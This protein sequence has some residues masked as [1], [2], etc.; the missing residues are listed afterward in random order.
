MLTLHEHQPEYTDAEINRLRAENDRL[1]KKIDQLTRVKSKFQ[2]IIANISDGVL[3]IDRTGT[4]VETTVVFEAITNLKNEEV[5][6][7]AIWDIYRKINLTDS[8]IH[9]SMS[10]KCMPSI[11][12]AAQY[13]AKSL[14]KITH[15]EDG[16]VIYLKAEYFILRDNNEDYI[17]ITI[18]DTTE[19]E[20]RQRQHNRN[21]KRLRLAIKERTE[22]LETLNEEY[23][24]ANE[25]LLVVNEELAQQIAAKNKAQKELEE[26][27]IMFSSFFEQSREGIL[28][29]DNTGKIIDVNKVVEYIALLS[30]DQ[31]LGQYIWDIAQQTLA[32]PKKRSGY[33]A[34]YKE[35]VLDLLKSKNPDEFREEYNL[36]V[37]ESDHPRYIHALIFQII[38]HQ[39]KF[40]GVILRDNT[41]KYIYEEELKLYRD[42][43]ERLVYSKSAALVENEKKL[44]T[45]SDNFPN[46]FIY[47]MEKDIQTSAMNITYLS[48]RFTEMTGIEREHVLADA[49]A[50]FQ[51]MEP[52]Y[53]KYITDIKE[54]DHLEFT[55]PYH[56]A[57][58]E[59]RWVR[60]SAT[61][62]MAE[63]D[64]LINDGFV[65]DITEQVKASEALV[66]SEH[67][68]QS[69]FNR[70]Q[71]M[72][73]II[74]ANAIITYV[75]PS[76]YTTYG[77]TE[78]QMLGKS[79][80]SFIYPD[81]VTTVTEYMQYI[82]AHD[83]IPDCRYRAIKA[84]GEIAE[85][86]AVGVNMLHDP[87]I[88]GIVVTH[89]EVTK[90]VEAQKHI[91]YS[92]D[93]QRLLNS[94]LIP[95]QKS[96]YIGPILQATICKV[97]KFL[98]A[99]EASIWEWTSDHVNIKCINEWSANN[100]DLSSGVQMT[101]RKD[102]FLH[103]VAN[104]TESEAVTL[105][106]F[107]HLTPEL[108]NMLEQRQIDSLILMP[109][110]V[111]GNIHGMILMGDI[112]Q[113]QWSN[114]EKNL[115]ISVAQIVSSAL[116]KQKAAQAQIEAQQRIARNLERQELLNSVLV[117]LQKSNNL[118]ESI[119]SA[120]TEVGRYARVSRVSV[121]ELSDNE[122]YVNY[123]YEWCEVGIEP[124]IDKFNRY[125]SDTFTPLWKAFSDKPTVKVSDIKQLSPVLQHI[126]KQQQTQSLLF[127]PLYVDGALK[128][129][130]CFA[131]CH[132]QREWTDDEV[133]LLTGFAQILSSSLQQLKAEVAQE[134]VRQAM[135]TVLDNTPLQIYV[136]D[137]TTSEIL[138]ANLAVKNALGLTENQSLDQESFEKTYGPIPAI[139]KQDKI[140]EVVTFEYHNQRTNSWTQKTGSI[141][142]WIDGRLVHIIT[143]IDITERKKMELELL[144]A[145]EK[146]EESDRLKSAFLANMSHEIRTPMNGIVGFAQ[147]IGREEI[148]E[149]GKRHLDIISE[150]CNVLLKLVDDII[151]ISKIESHQMKITLVPCNLT[152]FM[153]EL[154]T[155]YQ[156]ILTKK[157]K[158]QVKFTAE[159]LPNQTFAITDSIRLRQI[160]NNLIDNAIKFT[161]KGHIKVKCSIPNDGFIHFTVTDTGIG[162]PAN[163]Q[164]IIFERFRQVEETKIYNVSGTG[165]GL[166]I[167][168]NLAQLMGG[169]INVVSTSNKGSTFHFTIKHQ[170]VENIPTKI[171]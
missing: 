140:N 130:I 82:V 125:A 52:E 57:S 133:A 168:K 123:T 22:E 21:R 56:S 67:R 124:Q 113:R 32:Y 131:E 33:A 171:V 89:T 80:F 106:D 110:F 154:N 95:L 147:L 91:E 42:E 160:I 75:T 65:V 41:E 102:F 29:L 72:V 108:K 24:S 43:L 137:A 146:A 161:N 152:N 59:E 9:D 99:R 143:T 153:T 96:D 2:Q 167:A 63:N 11:L 12:S 10:A 163:R 112:N 116:Q 97:G 157:H 13:K 103:Q 51:L 104:I 105:S 88:N 139:L 151:D 149:E 69:L 31:L 117:P 135:T 47:R 121:F 138:F 34:E 35:M 23:A 141:I 70:L 114:D 26:S 38:I 134:A 83:E 144:D 17:C 50:L 90:H 84:N 14:Q 55:M 60:L 18:K 28:L 92:L 165:L 148:S 53:V 40:L 77:Y 162:I 37:S 66:F 81:D 39:E 107:S 85:V 61:T 155:S 132:Y 109:L 8:L 49:N 158:D 46:G 44:R 119:G 3:I 16:S 170:P 136:S 159:T 48:K 127:L 156:Q 86:K 93:K 15:D 98:R 129:C 54:N 7:H 118:K 111:N 126:L 5:V 101:F 68:L 169:D 164:N 20:E 64:L 25:E 166:A 87:Y 150:N 79:V 94:I 142:H 4:I 27:R 120:I 36:R 78:E 145:K 19:E 73:T 1:R 100:I 45:L 115:L 6:G 58:G 62:L 128:G 76:C 71:D 74:D 30:R 122:D